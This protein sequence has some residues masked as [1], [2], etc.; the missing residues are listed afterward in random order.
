LALLENNVTADG[1]ARNGGVERRQSAVGVNE[2]CVFERA[3][4]L[5]YTKLE[6]KL[7]TKPRLHA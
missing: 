1:Y 5:T 4:T 3:I 7:T 6:F 2:Q